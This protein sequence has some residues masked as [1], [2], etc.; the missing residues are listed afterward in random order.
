MTRYIAIALVATGCATAR[1]DPAVLLER[2]RAF[3]AATAERGM[4]GFLEFIAPDVTL[5][6]PG[7]ALQH[8]RDA[9]RDHWKDLLAQKGM[10]RWHPVEGQLAASGDLGYT[11]GLYELHATDAKGQKQDHHGKY[12]T[13]WRK[14]P[15]GVW[16]VVSDLGSPGP[17]PK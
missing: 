11:I 9:M 8:G 5:L 17:A 4:D 2:D 6:P 13:V 1:P 15:D 16:R 7:E 10:I 12:L 3:D 14:D